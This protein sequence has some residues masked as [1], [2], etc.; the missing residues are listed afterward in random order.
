MNDIETKLK[1][2]VMNIYNEGYVCGIAKEESF[3]EYVKEIMDLFQPE[4][5]ENNSI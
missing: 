2:I 3:N 5:T 4:K 1:E